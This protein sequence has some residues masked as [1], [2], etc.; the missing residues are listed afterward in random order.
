MYLQTK[1]RNR[2][3]EIEFTDKDKIY[4]SEAKT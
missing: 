4:A 3:E 2:N 1:Y